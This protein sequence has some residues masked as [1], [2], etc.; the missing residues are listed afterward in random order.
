MGHDF[1]DAP[2]KYPQSIPNGLNLLVAL[3]AHNI[4]S[5]STDTAIVQLLLLIMLDCSNY[6]GK[7]WDLQAF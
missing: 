3:L 2:A 6:L 5:R 7:N 1:Y 4:S